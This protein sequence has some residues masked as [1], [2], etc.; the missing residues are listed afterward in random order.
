MKRRCT[1][2]SKPDCRQ[3]ETKDWGGKRPG[4][5]RPQ[6]SKNEPDPAARVAVGWY[7][8]TAHVAEN[9]KAAGLTTETKPADV[10]AVVLSKRFKCK[11]K[12]CR[13]ALKRLAMV[14]HG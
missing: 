11:C 8:V 5:G 10:V 4:A 12:A 3:H 14:T 1:T 7:R 6:G 13:T 9:L 2:C